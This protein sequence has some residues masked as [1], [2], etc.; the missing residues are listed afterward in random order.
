MFDK[1]SI[2]PPSID[3]PLSSPLAQANLRDL[4]QG[5]RNWFEGLSTRLRLPQGS[6]RAEDWLSSSALSDLT[7]PSPAPTLSGGP[8]SSLQSHIFSLAHP[9]ILID[10][11][12]HSPTFHHYPLTSCRIGWWLYDI[13]SR[14]NLGLTS[15][16]DQERFIITDLIP[17]QQAGILQP[18]TK[19]PCLICGKEYVL[20]HM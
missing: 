3:P 4:W 8:T 2:R 14:V 16:P 19:V 18:D 7:N 6:L 10:H 17:A 5:H 13:T 12:K 15:S 1:S 20:G 11:V 9:S